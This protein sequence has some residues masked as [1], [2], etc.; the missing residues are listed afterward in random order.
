MCRKNVRPGSTTIAAWLRCPMRDCSSRLDAVCGSAYRQ[1]GS[2]SWL[3]CQLEFPGM[4]AGMLGPLFC[5]PPLVLPVRRTCPALHPGPSR[6]SC[7]LVPPRTKN[8]P[9]SAAAIQPP[10]HAESM[11]V[12]QQR[13]RRFWG[14]T[15]VQRGG[16]CRQ[17]SRSDTE[18]PG[19]GGRL[20][21]PAPSCMPDGGRS[22]LAWP[23]CPAD[24]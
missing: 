17:T 18:C 19:G 12:R 5:E 20:H 7:Q 4:S 10:W 13:P 3:Q 22:W 14:L 11:P 8:R 9:D 24:G 6:M 21:E 2:G 23:P 15:A 16:L 1:A